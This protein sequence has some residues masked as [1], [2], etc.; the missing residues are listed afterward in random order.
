MKTVA[1]LLGENL[2]SASQMLRV[3][4]NVRDTW[5][6]ELPILPGAVYTFVHVAAS[7][8]WTVTGLP[9]VASRAM[10]YL[11]NAKYVDLSGKIHFGW[12][13][14][15]SRRV[16]DWLTIGQTMFLSPQ[17][18]TWSRG[19]LQYVDPTEVRFEP[20]ATQRDM[21][22]YVLTSDKL[23]DKPWY[24]RDLQ[25]SYDELFMNNILPFGGRG[26]YVSPI[27]SLLPTARLAWLIREHD[28]ARVDGRKI[29]DIILAADDNLVE[30]IEK[31]ITISVNLWNGAD[32]EKNGIPIVA[33]NRI[34]GNSDSSFDVEKFVGRLGIADIPEGLNREEFTYNYVNEIASTIG[35]GLRYFWYDPRGTNRSLEQ[36]N[37]QRQTVKGPSYFVRSEERHLNSSGIL[38]KAVFRFVEEVDTVS[39]KS[40]AEILQ[41]YAE[42]TVNFR[43]VFGDVLDGESLLAWLQQ[44]RIFPED[45][46]LVNLETYGDSTFTPEELGA[47]PREIST[48]PVPVAS[49]ATSPTAQPRPVSASKF[50]RWIDAELARVKNGNVEEPAYGEITLD[51]SGH[52]VDV[53][54]KMWT[55]LDLFVAEEKAKM[56][57]GERLIEEAGGGISGLTGT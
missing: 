42:A 44:Q 32:P 17:S 36:V 27:L 9:R 12:E 22:A 29:R 10:D 6:H 30:A 33:L 48:T 18:T 23:T 16:M 15:I 50:E 52:V 40:R 54:R 4:Q 1:G 25:W 57:R 49:E 20:P 31:A 41:M 7:R 53:R 3:G 5:L 45:I 55:V 8:E 14:F 56:E 46:D 19:P 38:G 37:E 26:M 28:Q 51:Q 34:G 13:D 35:L 11:N 39:M 43:Q 47:E 21:S 24:Y 2:P